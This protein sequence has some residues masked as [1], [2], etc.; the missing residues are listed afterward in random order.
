M[1]RGTRRIFP[2]FLVAVVALGILFPSA[3][4]AAPDI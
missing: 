2:A 1:T 3:A 4:P